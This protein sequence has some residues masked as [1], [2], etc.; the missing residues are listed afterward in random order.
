MVLGAAASNSVS[1]ADSVSADS[2]RVERQ[3]Q[4]EYEGHVVCTQM[5]A[6]GESCHEL[7]A[8]LRAT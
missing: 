3:R 5:G 4:R 1:K 8:H 7:A 2:A 6:E